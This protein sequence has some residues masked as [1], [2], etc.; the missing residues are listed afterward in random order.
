MA[1]SRLLQSHG[2]SKSSLIIKWCESSVGEKIDLDGVGS[3]TELEHE[4]KP[5]KKC[6]PA[7]SHGRKVQKEKADGDTPKPKAQT[8]K[9]EGNAPKPKRKSHLRDP[10]EEAPEIAQSGTKTGKQAPARLGSRQSQRGTDTSDVDSDKDIID[11]SQVL[12][13]GQ[14]TQLFIGQHEQVTIDNSF[15]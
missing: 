9:S 1:T 5:T 6:A 2:N 15:V 8:E 3:A 4:P 11:E 12:F 7:V 10:G 13:K 14:A